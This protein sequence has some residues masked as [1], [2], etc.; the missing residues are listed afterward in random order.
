MSLATQAPTLDAD[1]FSDDIIAD[2]Y[3]LYRELR[4]T[5]PAVYLSAHSVW[6]IGRHA[7][8]R[9]AL[10]DFTTFSSARGA[11]MLE[12]LAQMG[13]VGTVLGSD[14]PEHDVLRSVLSEKL[15]P[16]ALRNLH[17]FVN[18]RVNAIVQET[19][20]EGTFDAIVDLAQRLPVAV[21]GD[22][23]GLPREGRNI[24]IEG[25]DAIFHAFG[26]LTPRL[27][28]RLPSI[29]AYLQ[30]TRDMLDR[31]V[32]APNSWGS[33]VLDAAD[34]GRL[35]LDAARTLMS[36]YMIAGIDTTVNSIGNFI[37]L[38]ANRPDIWSALKENP[39]LIAGAYE[40][41][42]R[43]ESPVQGFFRTTTRDADVSGTVIPKDSRVFMCFGSGNRDERHFADPDSF[44]LHRNPTDHL[45]FGYGTHGCAGQ[46]LARIEVPALIS[47]LLQCAES[48]C[49][50]GEAVR[51][52]SPVVR[53]FTALPVTVV[54]TKQA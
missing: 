38:L 33:A 16:R 44:D 3:A 4:D 13:T 39:K 51:N 47:A 52:F 6:A 10:L 54:P 28:E 50:A 11:E 48:I 36:S 31:D 14:P 19:V 15:A 21:V 35:P 22:L 24:L 17:G 1:I 18:E 2:P 37:H 29:A 8:L 40:E 43:F 45:A 32:L 25:A 30:Y 23:I 27:Q 7:D 9:A 41:V 34:E 49:P 42:L 53:S 20:G 26:P 46:G 5:A 12:D